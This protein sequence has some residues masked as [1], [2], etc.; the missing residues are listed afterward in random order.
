MKRRDFLK[1]TTLTLGA[2]AVG[3][4]EVMAQDIHKEHKMPCNVP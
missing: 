3:G 1:K 4:K 2:I